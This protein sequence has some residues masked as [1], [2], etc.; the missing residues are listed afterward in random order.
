MAKYKFL[1]IPVKPCSHILETNRFLSYT[2]KMIELISAV[3][4]PERERERDLSAL[5]IFFLLRE[6]LLLYLLP[7]TFH[8]DIKI[9]FM[10]L[11]CF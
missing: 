10:A 11:A 1:Y 4:H 5:T 8:G 7:L 2:E 6:K 3:K 9:A